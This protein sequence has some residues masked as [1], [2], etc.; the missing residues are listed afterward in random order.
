[1]T[2]FTGLGNPAGKYENTRHNAGFLAADEMI[3]RLNPSDISKPAFKGSLY[4]SGDLL[5]L[6][7]LTYMNNS[8]V[9]VC[10]VASF[11]GIDT[12]IVAHDDLD[13]SF[14]AL[15]FKRGGANGGHNGLK[16][17]DALC[18]T[19]YLRV[20]IGIGRPADSDVIGYVLSAWSQSERERL[21]AVISRAADA[22]LALLTEPLERVRSEFTQKGVFDA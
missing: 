20:R 3:R 10:A 12:L 4:R 22:A 13:L 2:L 6:K 11:Y 8:G 1:M 7:P 19:D 17:I 16:S 14:G 21:E 18:G 9:S 15:R 5:I